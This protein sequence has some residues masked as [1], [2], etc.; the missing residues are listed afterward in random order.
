MVTAE[1]QSHS[2][3]PP[4]P[5]MLGLDLL[6][7]HMVGDYILQTDRMAARKLSDWRVRA[8]HVV[9]YSLPFSVVLAAHGYPGE[10][11]TFMALLMVTHFITDSRRWASGEKW[12]PKPI[13]VDQ[14]I[15]LVTLAVL[16]RLL[17]P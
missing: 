17:L 15:H 3:P 9:A 4:R 13:M 14:T 2:S 10:W 5:A 6:A 7:A 1:V 12:A 8:V 11:R 16:G